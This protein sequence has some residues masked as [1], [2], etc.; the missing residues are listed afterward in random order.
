MGATANILMAAV[1]A[2]GTTIINNAAMEPEITN[3]AEFL[4]KMGAKINGL[5]TSTLGNRGD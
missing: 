1:L 2:K 5:N 3:L 4:I